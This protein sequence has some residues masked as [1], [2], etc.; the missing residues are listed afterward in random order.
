[1]APCVASFSRVLE[2]LLKAFR[3]AVRKV[4]W[5]GVS[6]SK[7]MYIYI[8]I[9]IMSESSFK[10]IIREKPKNEFPAWPYKWA[11]N[12]DSNECLFLKNIGVGGNIFL[13]MEFGVVGVF[14]I[15]N[16]FLMFL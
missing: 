11:E 5:E 16:W 2:G 4:P 6:K 9:Y 15:I 1:M 3:K 14:C 8:Y 7:Y 10:K 12:A 13:Q